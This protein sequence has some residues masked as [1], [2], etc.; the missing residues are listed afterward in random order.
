[1]T[2]LPKSPAATLASNPQLI[3]EG[4][5]I[6]KWTLIVIGGGIGV[7]IL[8][9]IGKKIFNK[10]YDAR[11][12]EKELK[13]VEVRTSNVTISEAEAVLI[14]QN[15]FN[16]MNRIGTDQETI[17]RNLEKLQTKDDLLLIF[18]KFGVKPYNGISMTESK[19][20][21]WIGSR[22]LNLNGWL[23]AEMTGKWEQPTINI[24]QKLGVA[25]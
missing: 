5:K 8:Y 2:S 7:F 10:D 3:S 6:I 25:Y 18:R 9:R 11:S 1:M 16:S 12:I 23:Q 13:N 21:K 15:I 19:I 20:R 4:T 14:T 24:F 22:D 17:L